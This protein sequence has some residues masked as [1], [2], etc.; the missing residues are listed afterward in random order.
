MRDNK[1][2]VK[3]DVSINDEGTIVLFT[4]ETPA[5]TATEFVERNVSLESWQWLGNGFACEPRLAADII[6]RMQ[7]EGLVVQ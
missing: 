6:E 1:A 4:P 7:A 5:A 2:K 3:I